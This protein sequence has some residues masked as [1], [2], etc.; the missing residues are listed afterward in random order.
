MRRWI[1]AGNWKM[2]MDHREGVVFVKEL[3][4]GLEGKDPSCEVVL[5]PPFTTLHAVAEAL[6]DSQVRTGAQDLYFEESGA[7]TGE[8]SGRMLSAIGVSYALAGH[9]ERRHVFGEDD[10]TVARKLGAAL[11]SGL[12]PVLCVG[13]LLEER[14]AGNATKVVE[15]QVR[16]ALEGLSAEE[17]GRVVVAYEP[18]WAIGTGK[19]ATPGD[20]ADMHTFIRKIL[21]SLFGEQ[22]AELTPILYG[23]SVK[24]SNAREL[25]EADNV[26][27]VLVGGASL[28]VTSFLSIIFPE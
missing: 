9:S 5:F 3:L 10:T 20:A 18:V 12:D 16:A 4:A 2:N 25:L 27:G 22:A 23:G 1:V 13:E 15:T 26:D 14:E 24:P 19:T 8:I 11:R 7:Y 6:A 21:D 28:E 17:F